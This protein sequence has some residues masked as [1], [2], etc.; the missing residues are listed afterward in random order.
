M[1]RVHVRSAISVWGN[2]WWT[3]SQS[4]TV[5][6]PNERDLAELMTS[7]PENSPE[8]KVCALI[9]GSILYL[10]SIL[11]RALKFCAIHFLQCRRF[12]MSFVGCILHLG[13]LKK[14]LPWY[15]TQYYLEILHETKTAHAHNPTS[16]GQVAYQTNQLCVFDVI[17]GV[18]PCSA[19]CWSSCVPINELFVFVWLTGVFPAC[20]SCVRRNAN[21]KNTKRTPCT[22]AIT[23]ATGYANYRRRSCLFLWIRIII[24]FTRLLLC[25]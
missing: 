3:V 14:N 10:L 15:C 17:N 18:F 20:M 11:P 8:A 24:T 6:N 9:Q 22:D 4:S 13:I 19:M 2:N 23:H 25:L 1:L 12:C 5:L 7:F 21:W 16:P